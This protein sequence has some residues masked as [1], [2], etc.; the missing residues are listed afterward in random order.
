MIDSDSFLLL[1]KKK[2]EHQ[3]HFYSAVIGY[4]TM[5]IYLQTKIIRWR[6]CRWPRT[7][8]DRL[9]NLTWNETRYWAAMNCMN[10]YLAKVQGSP[11]VNPVS[12]NQRQGCN[13][14]SDCMKHSLEQLFL[15]R[16][17]D[18]QERSM[19]KCLHHRSEV[20]ELLKK[21][22][23]NIGCKVAIQDYFSRIDFELRHWCQKRR[24]RGKYQ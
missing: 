8:E 1:Q 12:F 17:T 23:Q 24:A 11:K 9:L 2:R 14:R 19:W 18:W 21:S 13:N 10:E 5:T 7:H 3:L 16:L 6:Y 20:R 22:R 4:E 15:F